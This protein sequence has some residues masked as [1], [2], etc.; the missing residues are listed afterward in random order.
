MYEI[1]KKREIKEEQIKANGIVLNLPGKIPAK[2]L[3]DMGLLYEDSEKDFT[4]KDSDN[5]N[6]N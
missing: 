6:S 3:I 4:L 2:Y 5:L 1:G